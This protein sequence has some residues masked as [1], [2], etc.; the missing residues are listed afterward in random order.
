MVSSFTAVKAFE[1]K[2]EKQ[3]IE[4]TS[5]DVKAKEMAVQP[6]FIAVE[7]RNFEKSK[8]K[9]DFVKEA[10]SVPEPIL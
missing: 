2:N 9:M 1:I 7:Y 10:V 3:K 8:P 6:V 5:I 4:K